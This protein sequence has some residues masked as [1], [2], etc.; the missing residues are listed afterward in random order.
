MILISHATRSVVVQYRADIGA[1]FPHG[2]R[3]TWNDNDM[4]ALP[5]GIDETRLLR[6]F[7][8]NVPAPIV[9][10]YHFPSA[11]GAKPFAKQVLTAASMVM[12]PR[13]YVLNGM[14]TG[15][16]KACIWS[17]DYLKREALVNRML[18]V[19]PL[20]T[21]EF[22]WLK[23]IRRT[24]PHLRVVV[25][26]GSAD[27]RRRLLKENADIYVINHDGVKVI[28]DELMQRLD[29][30]VICFDEAAAYRNARAERS[31]LARK[32]TLRRKYVWAMTGSPTPSAPTDA[33]G[34]AWLVTPDTAPR[35]FV[36]F[37]HETMLQVS[38]FRWIPRRDSVETIA[39]VLQPSVRFTLDEIVELPP[40][41]EREI[42]VAIG[43]RQRAAYD[44]LRDHAAALL[45][46]G[47]VT[48]ANGGVVF[49]KMLQASI[50]WVYGDE[51]RK[52][53]ALDNQA[54]LDALLDVIESA[55][56]KVIVFSPF[57]SA[58]AGISATLKK[59]NIEFAEV[60]GDT[61][62]GERNQIF[63][64][65]QGTE[66]YKVL[67]AHPECMSHGL[68]L[69]AADTIVWF[70]PVTKLEVFEQANARITRV[71][72]AH[73]QQIIKLTGT[74]AERLVYRRLAD[75]HELQETIL[76]ML[77]ELA[78]YGENGG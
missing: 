47:T 28:F 31:K 27:R 1:L 39:A 66:K 22:T 51:D 20:S 3:F 6:N 16:T 37:R 40:V 61:P 41:I 54:R 33:F 11:D 7:D 44:A 75:K 48:A 24:L 10:H 69:T 29:I 12:N 73:K 43:P 46:E 32:L 38:Q 56:R 72:Q 34:L 21:L 78:G 18:V 42:E 70:G 36:S 5:H 53:I 67:N 52:I 26:S 68:T 9:E 4:L 30:D 55:E 58:T 50:G 63:T 45:R 14:G 77:A 64:A 76:D 25:L 49:T 15:K 23:E 65:F 74:P 62:A 71:G 13:S 57:K 2:K 59:H 17:F 35:S 8:L 19:A 60:T